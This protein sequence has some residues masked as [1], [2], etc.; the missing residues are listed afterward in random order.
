[1]MTK[2]E[3]GRGTGS[4]KEI[5][6]FYSRL[7]GEFIAVQGFHEA[8]RGFP[9]F[10]DTPLR[11]GVVCGGPKILAYVHRTKLRQVDGLRKEPYLWF[12]I[13]RE[14]SDDTFV[15]DCEMVLEALERAVPGVE[16]LRFPVPASVAEE[17]D[18]ES[19]RAGAPRHL[20]LT[21]VEVEPALEGEVRERR[22][23]YFEIAEEMSE[24][25]LLTLYSFTM[26][27]LTAL[28]AL[29]ASVIGEAGNDP[30]AVERE[31]DE[32]AADI[33]ALTDDDTENQSEEEG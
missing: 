7:I 27:L 5:G 21:L 2:S 9:A 22:G 18:D 19:V 23:I 10:A 14:S 11:E 24:E 28:L 3:G 17:P 30:S 15:V 25:E 12:S 13:C 26:D 8:H 31:L 32:L 6:D 1:M 33:N 4:G 16:R 20:T 29:G